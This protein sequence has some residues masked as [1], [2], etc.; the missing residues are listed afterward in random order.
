MR[1]R[2]LAKVFDP[3]FRPGIRLGLRLHSPTSLEPEFDVCEMLVVAR[4][5]SQ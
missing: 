4:G 2:G 1:Q 5:K 3:R